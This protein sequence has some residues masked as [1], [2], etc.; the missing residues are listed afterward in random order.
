MKDSEY[1][2]NASK[3]MILGLAR[4]A[5]SFDPHDYRKEFI[6]LVENWHE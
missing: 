4:N 3:Q 1:K 2:G 6:G 5:T